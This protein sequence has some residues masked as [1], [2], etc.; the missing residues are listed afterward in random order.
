MRGTSS[1]PQRGKQHAGAGPLQALTRPYSTGR[2]PTRRRAPVASSLID[3]ISHTRIFPLQ[4]PLS[5]CAHGRGRVGARGR[6]E[7]G[8]RIF[9]E[10]VMLSIHQGSPRVGSSH[11]S[12]GLPART[13]QRDECKKKTNREFVQI[14]RSFQQPHRYSIRTISGIS[15]TRDATGTPCFLS[16]AILERASPSPPSTIA[17]AWPMRLSGGAEM[18]AI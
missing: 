5:H 3:R 17:P 14:Y 6:Q 4:T 15:E 1:L 16:R 9:P 11:I 13:G 7:S 12:A 10:P 8:K 18:P 2:A